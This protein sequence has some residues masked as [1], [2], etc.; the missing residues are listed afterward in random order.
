[1]AVS[2]YLNTDYD[3]IFDNTTN[4]ILATS[5]VLITDYDTKFANT[6]NYIMATSNQIAERIYNLTTDHVA[7]GTYNKYI[8]AGIYEGDIEVKGHFI[9]SN[10]TIHGEKT[11]LVTDVFSTEVL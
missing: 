9:T 6:T 3:N 4:Y 8:V 10:I 1:M 7:N 5:N 11:K 2:N